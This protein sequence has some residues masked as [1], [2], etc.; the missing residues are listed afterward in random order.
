MEGEAESDLNVH[1]NLKMPNPPTAVRDLL[2]WQRSKQARVAHRLRF[3][4]P[5]A[6]CDKKLFRPAAISRNSGRIIVS[7]VRIA[8]RPGRRLG[9]AR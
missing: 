1:Q 2:T 4:I 9:E 8:G 5:V 7:V 6:D 3:G